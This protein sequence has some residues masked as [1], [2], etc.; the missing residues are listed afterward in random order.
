LGEIFTTLLNRSEWN[1]GSIQ[2][3]KERRI[4]YVWLWYVR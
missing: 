1:S 3:W 2:S 4:N